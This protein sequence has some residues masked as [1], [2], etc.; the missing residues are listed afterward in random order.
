M[1]PR[2][3][4]Q[5]YGLPVPFVSASPAPIVAQRAPTTSDLGYPIGQSWIDQV[6]NSSYVFIETINN[7]AQWAQASTTL[8]SVNTLTGN[9]GG[10]ISPVAGNINIVGAGGTLVS[11]AGSTLTITA[12]PQSF[13]WNNN[14]VSA[15]LAVN[16]GYIVTA[17]AQSFSLPAVSAVGDEIALML[18]GGVSWTITQGAGQSIRV[19]G[20]MSTGGAGG[21]V[22]TTGGGQTIWMICTTANLEWQALSFLGALNTL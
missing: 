12:A 15:A 8:G 17:G 18:N 5:G 1:P 20:S 7:L 16:N 9:S 4:S 14:A 13:T 19:L 11:G 3:Q 21:S 6:G 10:A 22:A 2:L